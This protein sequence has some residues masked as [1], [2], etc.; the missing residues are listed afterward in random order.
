M[1]HW[2]GKKQKKNGES[3]SSEIETVIYATDSIPSWHSVAVALHSPA[4]AQTACGVC[5]PN[6]TKT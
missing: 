2:S 3:E 1:K 5:H 4:Q 6:Q